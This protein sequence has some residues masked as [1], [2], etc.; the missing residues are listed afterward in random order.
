MHHL[1]GNPR[2]IKEI[3]KYMDVEYQM[4]RKYLYELLDQDKVEVHDPYT[5]PI[6][7]RR[8]K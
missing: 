2:T 3:A 6:R 7:Y 1:Q 4:V 5:K 8:K